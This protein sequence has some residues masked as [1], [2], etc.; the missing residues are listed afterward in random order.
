LYLGP[1]YALLRDE[2]YEARKMVRQRNGTIQ[3]ILV[4]Y[5]GVDATNETM[6]ALRALLKSD[7]YANLTVAAAIYKY[8]PPSDHNDT[9]SYQ[10]KLSKMT[11]ISLNKKLN[12]LTPEEMERV[13]NTIKVI[14]GWKPGKNETFNADVK[15]SGLNPE[16]LK[17]MKIKSMTQREHGA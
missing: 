7:R 16:V 12:Q 10:R 13:V 8:A 11:G 6:K 15:L 17:L 3:N 4:F 9:R 14:E 1:K 5:G 2:F